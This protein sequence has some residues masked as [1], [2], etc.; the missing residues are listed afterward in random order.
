[1]VHYYNAVVSKIVSIGWLSF[2][3]RSVLTTK[4]KSKQKQDNKL[5]YLSYGLRVVCKIMK[6]EE[7]I[8]D[9]Q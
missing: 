3:Q 5:K 7:V 2:D 9:S 8:V 4:E 6:T 1:M